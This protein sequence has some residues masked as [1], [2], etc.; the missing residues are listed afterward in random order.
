MSAMPKKRSAFSW[1]IFS[2]SSAVRPACIRKFSSVSTVLQG[3]SV[4]KKTLSTPCFR[5]SSPQRAGVSER[6]A[7]AVSSQMFG[8]PTTYRSTSASISMPP[9][10]APMIRSDGKRSAISASIF[11]VQCTT[12][13]EYGSRPA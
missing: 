12:S 8:L 3:K 11:G 4:A 10:C 1:R 5:I 13:G 6:V 9:M 7:K 2:S